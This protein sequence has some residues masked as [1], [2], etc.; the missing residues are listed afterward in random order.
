MIDDKILNVNIDN[1]SH[2]SMKEDDDDE[3]DININTHHIK[4]KGIINLGIKFPN[5]LSNTKENGIDYNKEI[6]FRNYI[7]TDPNFILEKL[8]YFDIISTVEKG[9]ERKTRKCIKD[10][11]N[12][13]KNPLNVVPKKNNMDLKRNLAPVLE[14]L[15][16]RTEIAI[17]EIIREN[18]KKQQLEN[19]NDNDDIDGVNDRNIGNKIKI[20]SEMQMKQ[21]EEELNKNSD[22]DYEES[23]DHSI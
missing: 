9:Y 7:P 6:I 11:I 4:N 17:M 5:N 18:I 20:S 13:E 1:M 3:E 14:R 21:V 12:L 16:K 19:A 22:D 15:N 10:F 23:S 2:L 8:S